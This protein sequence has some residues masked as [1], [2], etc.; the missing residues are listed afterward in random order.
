MWLV[1]GAAGQLG[2]CLQA[3]LVE[4]GI[5]HLA[6]GREEVDITDPASVVAAVQR[7]APSVIVNAAAWTNVDAAEDSETEAMAVNRDG[8][9]NVAEA[10]AGAA[11]R[12]VHVSTDYV[13]TGAG[14]DP[15]AESEPANP[16]NA[17]GRTK[18]AGEEAVRAAHPGGAL[19][20]RTAWLYSEH[21]RNFARTMA[22]RA[23]VGE[24]VRVV[25]DQHGTPTSARDLA[26]HIVDLVEAGIR[27]GQYHGLSLIHI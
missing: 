27:T 6:C 8:A 26:E 15:I 24:A 19:V 22:A 5:D 18:W 10:A 21:G 25:D 13:F 23:I 12:L 4:R 17:Y 1:F 14:P 16:V 9:R 20:V 3:V 7:A 2:R 11:A